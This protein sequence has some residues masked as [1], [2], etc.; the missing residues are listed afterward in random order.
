[1]YYVVC[2]RLSKMFSEVAN[3]PLCNDTDIIMKHWKLN[4]L[5]IKEISSIN[6]NTYIGKLFYK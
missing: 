2:I 1:M 5:Q 6:A 4:N 3:F